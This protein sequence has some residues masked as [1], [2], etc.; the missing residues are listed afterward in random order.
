MDTVDAASGE[1]LDDLIRWRLEGLRLV[2]GPDS[3]DGL[4]VD[5]FVDAVGYGFDFGE[6]GHASA[7]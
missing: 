2:A 6:F 7:V 3:P 1:D 5:S 4:T